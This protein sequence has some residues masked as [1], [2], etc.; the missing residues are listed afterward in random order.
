MSFRKLSDSAANCGRL[1][2]RLV[3]WSDEAIMA[4]L[5]L[6]ESD[7]SERR[8]VCNDCARD[9]GSEVVKE[10]RDRVDNRFR[11]LPVTGSLTMG[12]GRGEAGV[13]K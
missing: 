2:W 12:T 6:A 4:V 13:S 10:A 1:N 9:W 7:C 11:Y 5:D 3:R 8:V